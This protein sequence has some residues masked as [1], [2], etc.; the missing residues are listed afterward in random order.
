MVLTLRKRHDKN[1]KRKNSKESGS[2]GSECGVGGEDMQSEEEVVVEGGTGRGF[3]V[4]FGGREEAESESE[5]SDGSAAAAAAAAASAAAN[6]K[7]SVLIEPSPS[8]QPAWAH[9]SLEQHSMT[10]FAALQEEI[11]GLSFK[12]V[13][14]EERARAA[15]DKILKCT[16]QLSAHEAASSQAALLDDRTFHREAAAQKRADLECAPSPPPPPIVH[17]LW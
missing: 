2:S 6:E 12:L 17:A 16:S 9:H 1:R 14:W 11:A 3:G 15:Q 5:H 7:Y 13:D 10:S 4:D 8:L